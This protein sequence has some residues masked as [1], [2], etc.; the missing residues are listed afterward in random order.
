LR[1]RADGGQRDWKKLEGYL[2][3]DDLEH[4]L[5]LLKFFDVFLGHNK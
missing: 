4:D 5:R 1:F 2:G 3:D